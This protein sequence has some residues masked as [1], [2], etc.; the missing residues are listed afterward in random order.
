[1]LPLSPFITVRYLSPGEKSA[2][3]VHSA[4]VEATGHPGLTVATVSGPD[5][6]KSRLHAWQETASEKQIQWHHWMFLIS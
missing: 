2:T 4:E 5:C 6:V 3:E 1:M